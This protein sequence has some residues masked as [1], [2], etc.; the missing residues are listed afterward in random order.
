ML[1]PIGLV[2]LL[3]AEERVYLNLRVPSINDVV[4]VRIIRCHK[5]ESETGACAVMMGEERED[6]IAVARLFYVVFVA[7]PFRAS[8]IPLLAGLYPI[9][10]DD[11]Q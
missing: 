6:S 1:S 7:H 10:S 3:G 9:C 2:I 4:P 11:Q 8:P 5:N